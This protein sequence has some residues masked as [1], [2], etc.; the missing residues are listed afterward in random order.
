M[1]AQQPPSVTRFGVFEIDR[2]SGELRKHGVRIR[3]RAQSFQVLTLLVDRAGE[4]VTREAL[5]RHIWSTDTFVD[6]ERGLN[7]AINRLREALGETADNPRFIETLPKRGYRFIAPV[8]HLPHASARGA[9]LPVQAGAGAAGVARPWL[10]RPA[11][12]ALAGAGFLALVGLMV[13]GY[14]WLGRRPAAPAEPARVVLA[15]IDNLTGEAAFDDT[16]EQALTVTL[17]QSPAVRIVPAHE[18]ARTLRLMQRPAAPRLTTDLA[19]DVCRRIGGAAVLGGSLSRLGHEYM[20]GLHALDCRTGDALARLQARASRKDGVLRALDDA[21]P[22]IREKLGEPRESIRR[23]DT[24]VHDLLTTGSLEAFEAYTSG[25]RNVIARGGWS[26]VPF[27]ERAIE[28]DPEFAYA[29]AALGLVLGTLGEARR[30]S[31]HAARAY[32]LRHRVSEWERLFIT[33]QYHD[34]VT[35]DLDQAVA[36]C[37]VWIQTYPGDRTAHNRLAGA[38]IQVGQPAR[39]LA[40]LEAARRAGRDHPIDVDQWAATLARLDRAEEARPV[41]R[42]LLAE[43]PDRLPLRRTA[44]RLAFLTGDNREMA[45]HLEWAT[46]TPHAEALFAEQA[47]A[48]ARAGRLDASRTWLRR[49]VS[50][51]RRERAGAAAV[52]SAA[53]AVR[54]ALLGNAREARAEA[55]AALASEA[56]WETRALAAVA[57]ARIGD[58]DAAGELAAALNAERPRGTLVQ[59]YWLPAIRAQ[60]ALHARNPARAVELLQAAEPYELADTRLPL[61]PAYLRGEAHLAAGDARRADAEFRKLLR[62]RGLVASSVLG[63]LAQLG[64]GRAR[65]R[66][67]DTEQ[68][69]AHYAGLLATWRDAEAGVPVVTESRTEYEAIR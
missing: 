29:H 26:N 54:E 41:V 2:R 27:F 60:S 24:R 3:L 31:A 58:A 62:H 36:T 8:A 22:G 5:Q 38:Y 50:A 35:G 11:A 21:V 68:A 34:R 1:D 23:F 33:A 39:A 12:A 45:A 65:A 64:V 15:D 56:S 51:V 30:S 49:A 13:A 63:P 6:F 44:Y 67:G 9:D 16:L 53:H 37:E 20:L 7:K 66:A 28:L 52:W 69:K 48:D 40:S 42:A 14:A 46:A 47:E 59:H 61:L 32:A 17:E 10:P 25:E 43:T 4:V 19:G 57:L 55:R 18:I